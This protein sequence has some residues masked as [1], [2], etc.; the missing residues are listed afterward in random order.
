VIEAGNVQSSRRMQTEST[1]RVALEC[2][3][4]VAEI[5]G[6]GVLSLSAGYWVRIIKNW[7]GQ[8]QL[9]ELN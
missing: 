8:K 6:K 2:S 5:T 4:F 1:E 3:V 7:R 9:S